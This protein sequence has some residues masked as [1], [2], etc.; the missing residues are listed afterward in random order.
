MCYENVLK[1]KEVPIY[2]EYKE[3]KRAS[4]CYIINITDR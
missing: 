2:K 4:T 3:R 1:L